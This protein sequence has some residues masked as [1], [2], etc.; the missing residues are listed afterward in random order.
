MSTNT[1]GLLPLPEGEEVKSVEEEL[2]PTE[3][4]S[5]ESSGHLIPLG[6]ARPGASSTQIHIALPTSP[7]PPFPSFPFPSP[8][9]S[10][11]P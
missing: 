1:G 8:T 6:L 9:L 10:P 3:G 11:D 7:S 2:L 5:A 4:L